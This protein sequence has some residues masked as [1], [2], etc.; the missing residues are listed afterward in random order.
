MI[1]FGGFCYEFCCEYCVCGW[2]VVCGFCWVVVVN[3]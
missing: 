1:G 3:L 2:V